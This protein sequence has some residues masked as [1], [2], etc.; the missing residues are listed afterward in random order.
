M[1]NLRELFTQKTSAVGAMTEFDPAIRI[2]H[3]DRR[4]AACECGA[5]EDRWGGGHSLSFLQRRLAEA[6]ST[7]WRDAVVTSVSTGGLITADTI[8]DGTELVVWNHVDQTSIVRLGEPV[9]LH[10]VYRVLAI[11]AQRISIADLTN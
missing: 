2:D 6:T 4:D 1:P 7:K 10:T 9:S 8:D 11:G 5:A 3:T